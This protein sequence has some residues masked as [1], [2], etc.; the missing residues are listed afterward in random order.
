MNCT[1]C[2]H[3]I[4]NQ[5]ATA[6][7]GPSRADP[8]QRT[9]RRPCTTDGRSFRRRPTLRTGRHAFPDRHAYIYSRTQRRQSSGRFS[10]APPRSASP[11]YL[12]HEAPKDRP[13]AVRQPR[14]ADGMPERV[15]RPAPSFCKNSA[16]CKPTP[17]Q[18]CG[19]CR[20]RFLQNYA[21]LQ[22]GNA[23]L[24]FIIT[25]TSSLLSYSCRRLEFSLRTLP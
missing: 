16:F 1:T 2:V 4:E 9:L 24:R 17:L 25:R 21:V 3:F 19:F 20:L 13:D 8:P 12:L 22:M 6:G 14:P 7:T 5:P 10:G 18:N 15:R 23:H 11:G